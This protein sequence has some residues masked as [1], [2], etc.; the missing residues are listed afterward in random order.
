MQKQFDPNTFSAMQEGKSV[1]TYRKTIVA[2]VHVQILNPFNQEPQGLI[3]SGNPNSEDAIVQTWS[4][5]EDVFFRRMNKRHFESGTIIPV[6]PVEKTVV[7]QPIIEQSTDEQLK[8]M[9]G[10]PFYT[11]SNILVK[12]ESEAF[13]SRILTMAREMEKSEKTIKAIEQRLS[14][15]EKGNLFV[16]ETSE[17]E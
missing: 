11:L 3:L 10:K 2:Q 9:L 4:V 16:P 5:P 12:T 17:S 7:E 15:L 6:A 14:E 8:E 13:V 1:G